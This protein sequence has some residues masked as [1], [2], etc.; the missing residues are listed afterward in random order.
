MEDHNTEW[1]ESWSDDCLGT[2]CAFAN[3]DGGK[4][5]IG[6][7]DNGRTVGIDEPEALLKRLP[8]KI[9]N[10]LGIV[11][12]VR[13]DATEPLYTISIYVER[14]PVAVTLDGKCYVRSGNTTQIISGREM[15]LRIMEDAG[16]SWT[17]TPMPGVK[18]SDL[19]PEAIM[20]F[21]MRGVRTGRMTP[22]EAALDAGSLLGKLNL[23]RDGIP[24]RAAA[25]LFH[26][27]PS[28]HMGAVKVR[29]AMMDGPE[30]LYMD[31]LDGP[32]IMLANRTVEILLTK[33]MYRPVIYEGVMRIEHSLYPEYAIREAVMNAIIHNDYSSSIDIQIKV[34]P[35]DLTIYNEGGLP[36]GWTLEKLIGSHKSVPRNPGL[37]T[38]FYRAGLIKSFGR[39]IGKIMAQ[40]E[41]RDVPGPEFE[42]DSGFAIRFFNGN[43]SEP[44]TSSHDSA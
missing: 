30:I 41:G 26:P 35:K 31:E 13:L 1:T 40:F 27:N 38:A 12:F 34:N 33:Y 9:R 42:F 10:K 7:D 28:R 2:I 24:T 14:S 39:G 44:L 6:V 15:E 3:T 8:G 37:A 36:I 19:S 32:L 21:K 20:D 4:M 18:V 25:L 43:Y 23:L 11:P 22:K 5:I 29:I 17:D 16:D